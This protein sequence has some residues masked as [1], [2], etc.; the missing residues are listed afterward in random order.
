[1]R[2]FLRLLA[3]G[4]SAIA[5]ALALG[6]ASQVA[7]DV[8]LEELKRSYATG[9]SRFVELDGLLVHY[10]DEGQGPA[11][12]LLHGMGSSLHTWDAWAESLR[13]KYRVIRMDLPGFGLTGPDPRDDYRI[14]AY[15]EFLD[16]LRKRLELE[17]FAVAGNSFGGQIAWSYAVAHPERVQALVLVDAAGYRIERPALVFRLARVPVVSWLMTRLDPGRITEKTLRDCYADQ[18]KVTPELI[19]R[20]RKLALR[21]GNRRAFVARVA[22]RAKDRTAEIAKVRAPTVVLWGAQDRLIPLDHAYRFQRAIP[23][24]KL[25]VYQDA[26]HVPMEEIGERSAAD[27]DAFLATALRPQTAVGR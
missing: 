19:E 16:R 12:V 25:V 6:I 18:R 27:V 24:A 7:R 8:P 13:G 15:V 3:V 21:E 1:M 17:S 5:A 9:A 10:R 2:R 22:T 14:D 26:G 20:Y 23:G 4:L 11:F